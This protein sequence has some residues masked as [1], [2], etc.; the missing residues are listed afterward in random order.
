MPH[1]IDNPRRLPTAHQMVRVDNLVWLHAGEIDRGGGGMNYFSRIFIVVHRN[2]Q[3]SV[4]KK[5]TIVFNNE[6]K[7]IFNLSR[8]EC[9]LLNPLNTVQCRSF[10]FPWYIYTCI[11][12]WIHIHIYLCI[13]MSTYICI[14]KYVTCNVYTYIRE[15]PSFFSATRIYMFIYIYIYIYI[16]ICIYLYIHIHI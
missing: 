16:Y 10:E 15:P 14:C 11:Y 4:S 6:K 13:Y 7:C 2:I 1:T 8:V 3:S 12:T 9:I 5:Q